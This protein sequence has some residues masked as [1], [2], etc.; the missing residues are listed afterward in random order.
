MQ[1]NHGDVI[2]EETETCY[3]IDF[4]KG[5]GKVKYSKPDWTL[6]RALYHQSI[7]NYQKEIDDDF[8]EY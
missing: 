7:K 6:A 5:L 2:V 1:Y 8:F 3:L 4:Q